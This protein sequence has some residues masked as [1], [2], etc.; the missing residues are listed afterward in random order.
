MIHGEIYAYNNYI[1]CVRYGPSC[2]RQSEASKLASARDGGRRPTIETERFIIGRDLARSA[3]AVSG[4]KMRSATLLCVLVDV[5]VARRPD[6]PGPPPSP[7][8]PS[9][10]PPAFVMGKKGEHAA[11]PPPCLTPISA[12]HGP[13]PCFHRPNLQDDRG[14]RRD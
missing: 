1:T 7:P 10:P 5:V 14:L 8:P 11:A 2:V 4:C 13:P 12:S 3:L 6:Y 9:P